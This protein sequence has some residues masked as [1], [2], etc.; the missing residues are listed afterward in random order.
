MLKKF[1]HEFKEFALKGNVMDLAVGVIIGAA[2][3]SIVTALTSS[4]INPLIA[5]C[6]G[7]ANGEGVTV[8]GTFVIRG[9]T[10]DYGAFIT[11]VIN[12]LIMAFVLFLMVKAMN[13]M[14]S[15]GKKKEEPKAPTTK[16]CP[17]CF[18][19]ISVK[20]TRC[21]CCTTVLTEAEKE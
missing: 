16:E 10:F 14:M 13:K 9:V 18:S 17:Y 19:K 8:G 15:L 2:F 20:A 7:G 3:Q 11:A 1:I 6:T 5:V 21:P 4:F 12:F